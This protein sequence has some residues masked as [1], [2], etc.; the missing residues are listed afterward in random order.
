VTDLSTT[1]TAAATPL[2]A[3]TPAGAP[4]ADAP[5]AGAP[6]AGGPP[7]G[8][9]V[10]LQKAGVWWRRLR[11]WLVLAMVI[12][13][14]LA[15]Y[16]IYQTRADRGELDPDSAT[17]GGSRALATLLRNHD[18][19]VDE[20]DDISEAM[21]VAGEGKVTLLVPFPGLLRS[22]TVERLRDLPK[23]VRVVLVEPDPFTLEDLDLDVKIAE[24]EAYARVR[25]PT[26]GLPEA[27]SAGDAEVG[28]TRYSAPRTAT[29]CYDRSLVVIARGGAEIVLLG[30]R[31]PLTNYRLDDHGNAALSL[32]LLSAH[33]RLIWLLPRG[34][35]AGASDK[36][37][38]LGDI[39]P[40]WVSTAVLMLMIAGV[41]AALWRSRRLGPP[42]A[43]PLPVV[44]RSAETVEGR[45]RLYR[46][47]RARPEAYE[48]L[49]A[50]AFARLLPALG[51]G[52]EPDY[53]AVVAA[54]ADRSGRPM[55]EVQAVLYGPPPA[56]DAGLVAAADALDLIVK[57]TLDPIRVETAQHRL[58]G[59]GRP[60]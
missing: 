31:D 36:R 1:P 24:M 46:R 42:V 17:P 28:L 40:P 8:P 32:G 59:E 4:D 33:E 26:C 54:V 3:E 49:R 18:V 27:I 7:A 13:V 20:Y 37:A 44:V 19:T 5:A 50:G 34:P 57:N 39:L 60:Q 41:L 23:S 12:G 55:A 35:E 21:S 45:A 51:L 10:S 48:A 30:A 47:A 58:D 43:E 22:R 53:R 2:V 38:S 52:A 6:P 56:D 16:A 29:R 25:R 9:G 15:L 14:V 11:L